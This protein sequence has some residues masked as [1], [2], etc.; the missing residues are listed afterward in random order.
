M[1]DFIKRFFRRPAEPTPEPVELIPS[2]CITCGRGCKPWE[3]NQCAIVE[4]HRREFAQR[5]ET[6]DPERWDFID[7]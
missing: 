5:E 1:F 6:D 7:Q 3:I 2:C 4:A